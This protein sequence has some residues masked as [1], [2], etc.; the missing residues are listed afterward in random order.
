MAERLVIRILVAI[1]LALALLAYV[2]LPVP[3]DAQG[4]PALPAPAFKQVALY[5]LEVALLAFYG[6][7]LLA[8][9][10]FSGLLRGWLPIEISTRGAKFAGEADGAAVKNEAAIRSMERA[11]RQLTDEL[12]EAQIEIHSLQELVQRDN[13]QP[14]VGSKT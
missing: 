7:L 2:R 11:V 12:E 8:T 4:N 6:Y 9:P 10:V 5:R 1:A 13:T 3:L 14:K